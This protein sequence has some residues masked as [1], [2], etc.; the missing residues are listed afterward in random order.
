MSRIDVTLAGVVIGS[1]SGWD[2]VTDEG[3]Q[4]YD[5]EPSEAGR[6]AG[7][8]AD[9]VP[10]IYVDPWSGL[11]ETYDEGGRIGTP[12]HNFMGLLFS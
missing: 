2:K 7:I 3:L 9:T 4:F 12:V 11:V 10:S 6:K 8:T 5:F 1:A